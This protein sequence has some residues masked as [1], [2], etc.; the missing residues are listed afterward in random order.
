MSVLQG[1]LLGLIQGLGEFLPVSSSGHL[2]LSRFFLG[3]QTETASMKMLDIMLH[4]GTLIP[5]FIVFRKEWI[6]MILHPVRN[7]TL[8]L[9]LIASLPTLFIYFAAQMLVPS[10]NGFDVFNSGWFLGSS[11]LITAVFLLLCDRISFRQSRSSEK[12]SIPQ[13]IIMG[14]FQ[15]I[16]LIPGVS[17]SGSTI[18]GG[19]SAGLNRTNSARFSFMMS[20]PAIVGS[21]LMEG[22]EAIEK[23]YIS[24]LD[25][26][27]S[28]AGI[29]V[30]AVV[31]YFSITFMLKLIT[32]VPF[33][34]F[35]LYVAV[36]GLVFLVLQLTDASGVPPFA[37]PVS[38]S[39]AV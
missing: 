19:V 32:R 37:V 22:K 20:A 18:L 9:L 16:G 38:L 6:S 13:A 10:V 14:L 7:K 25:V 36:I 35:A 21:F 3:I 11:F 30:A 12:I 24:H 15:G 2:L 28:V 34:W 27:P 31:G 5:V 29:L 4:A 26:L 1:I 17:R 39:G 8:L 23:D 33:L